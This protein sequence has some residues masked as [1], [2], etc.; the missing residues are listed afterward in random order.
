VKRT[1]SPSSDEN[2]E[3]DD[4]DDDDEDYERD[5]SLGPTGIL[6]C[7]LCGTTFP[8]LRHLVKHA[9]RKHHIDLSNSDQANS[10]DL[11]SAS[12]MEAKDS[13]EQHDSINSNEQQSNL[14]DHFSFN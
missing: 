5:S 13:N 10:F 8:R 14:N 4:D 6:T 9:K 2:S 3:L 1:P 12:N 11:F 7:P